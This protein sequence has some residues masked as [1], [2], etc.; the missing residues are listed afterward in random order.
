MDRSH[1]LQIL[2]LLS[3]LH[4]HTLT[5]AAANSSAMLTC[6]DKLATFSSCL[7]FIAVFHHNLTD[8][9]APLCG[10]EFSA[11]FGGGSA[12]CLCDAALQR[13]IIE[14]PINSTKLVSLASVCPLKNQSS[15]AEIS[16]ETLCS[17]LNLNLDM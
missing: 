4:R 3:I 5:S 1:A 10:D 13:K 8:F 2:L 16:L 11:A 6:S 9:P 17:G 7:P 14:F 12:V 15:K